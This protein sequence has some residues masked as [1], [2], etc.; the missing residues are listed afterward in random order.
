[1]QSRTARDTEEDD[2]CETARWSGS[3]CENESKDLAHLLA[4]PVLAG[5]DLAPVRPRWISLP[6]ASETRDCD[7]AHGM[8][9]TEGSSSSGV[10]GTLSRGHHVSSTSTV[11]QSPILSDSLAELDVRNRVTDGD[12]HC[13]A[14]IRRRVSGVVRRAGG[15]AEGRRTVACFGRGFECCGTS[16]DQRL[17]CGQADG[18]P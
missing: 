18:A 7:Q 12:S 9:Q 10:Y 8:P 5:L 11:A 4:L 13:G 16:H 15:R 1:M 17:L 3:G 14:C 6:F 2:L